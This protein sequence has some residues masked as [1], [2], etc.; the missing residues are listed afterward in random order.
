MNSMSCQAAKKSKK[1]GKL[2]SYGI[3]NSV[4]GK[5]WVRWWSTSSG[6]PL[7]RG[8]A[9]LADVDADRR[10]GLYHELCAKDDPACNVEI[11]KDLDRTL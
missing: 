2:V 5:A 7:T 11:D 1:I 3:P 10:D 6:A 8:Q 4:R 9:F